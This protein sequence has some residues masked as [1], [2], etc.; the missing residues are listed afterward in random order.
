MSAVFV[1]NDQMALGLLRA[2]A[3]AGRRR[4]RD[5]V[6]VVGFD[7]IADAADYLPPLTTVRQDFDALG[8]RAVEALIG[9]IDGGSAKTDLVPTRL[10]VRESTAAVR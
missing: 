6:S 2:L 8:E 5:D 10:V 9:A 7:D 4:A 3:E 1:A